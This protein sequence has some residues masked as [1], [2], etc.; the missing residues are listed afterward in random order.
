LV[1]QIKSV[2]INDDYLLDTCE[3]HFVALSKNLDAFVISLVIADLN[4]DNKNDIV[5]ICESKYY[6]SIIF[7]LGNNKFVDPIQ[8]STPNDISAVIV[9]DID[10]DNDLDII[11]GLK[12]NS[13]YSVQI[14]FNNGI[15][16]FDQTIGLIASVIQPLSSI[17]VADINDDGKSDIII[18]IP[19]EN[20]I[21]IYLNKGDRIFDDM[22]TY[23]MDK[24]PMSVYATD[25][26]NDNKPDIIVANAKSNS[27]SILFNQ[28]DGTFPDPINY[29]VG[30]GPIFVTAADLNHD[31]QS[32]IILVN[33]FSNNIVIYLNNGS[34]NFTYYTNFSAQANPLSVALNDYNSDGSIDIIVPNYHSNNIQVFF[35]DGT[36][37]FSQST[38]YN[39]YPQPRPVAAADMNNDNKPDIVFGNGNYVAT[40]LTRCDL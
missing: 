1:S 33:Y 32:D 20:I 6:V 12:F 7:N 29:I 26:N 28:G 8:H 23:P 21:G 38:T 11:V 40:I 37:I 5:F 14:L 35:N 31:N 9:A 17:V 39:T 15:G 19:D 4:G 18:S 25:L 10:D 27:I 24:F 3:R 30:T 13:N 34:N 2:S 22:T 36:G 16:S